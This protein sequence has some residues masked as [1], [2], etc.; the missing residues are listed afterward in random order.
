MNNNTVTM[1][2]LMTQ[3]QS[4][5]LST[6]DYQFDSIST[7]SA[8]SSALEYKKA[9]IAAL[10]PSNTVLSINKTQITVYG[11]IKALNFK[12]RD[13]SSII[14]YDQKFTYIRV[15]KG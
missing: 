7:L 8:I 12:N 9:E 6:K 10:A 5:S 3:I 1:N 15:F 14:Y 4:L 13:I 2:V 11:N